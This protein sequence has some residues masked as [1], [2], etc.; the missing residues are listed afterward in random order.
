MRSQQQKLEHLQPPPLTAGQVADRRPLALGGESEP[1]EQL[2]RR[3]FS[4]A[5]LNA[6]PDLLNGLAHPLRR[7][8]LAELLRQVPDPYG[9]AAHD[10]SRHPDTAAGRAVARRARADLP[11]E[12]GG[13]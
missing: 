5:D 6:Q 4:P 12:R 1:L 11:G 13:E 8:Q 9:R 3:Q 2:P 10:A 7:V